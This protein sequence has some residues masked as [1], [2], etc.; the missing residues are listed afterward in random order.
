MDIG[1]G[2][3]AHEVAEKVSRLRHLLPGWSQVGSRFEPGV[4]LDTEV[5]LS[6]Y[7]DVMESGIEQGWMP[8]SA[9]T[10]LPGLVVPEALIALYRITNAPAVPDISLFYGFDKGEILDPDGEVY[11]TEEH[12]LSVGLIGNDRFLV[13]LTSGQ[14]M[15]SDHCSWRYGAPSNSR[16][17]APDMLTFFDRCMTGPMYREFLEEAEASRP[18]YWY[19]FLLDHGFA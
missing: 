3:Q 15:L 2:A 18:D 6:G 17:V 13:S 1:V 16:I 12:W 14:V 10:E 9:R 4:E 19:Q 8:E 5:I 7:R 11:R